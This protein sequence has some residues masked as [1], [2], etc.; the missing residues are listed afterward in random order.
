VLSFIPLGRG[1]LHPFRAAWDAVRP[2]LLRV[3][4]AFSTE[5]GAQE[6][7]SNI[8]GA[9]PFDAVTKEWLIG[10]QE[11]I[12]QPEALRRLGSIRA[13]EVRVPF[14]SEALDSPTL[15]APTFFHPKVYCFENTSTGEIQ[16]LSGSAN[17]TYR[18]L[19]TSI[20]QFLTWRGRNTDR[21]ADAF[22]DWWKELWDA[23]NSATA[24]FIDEY[25]AKRPAMP[26]PSHAL[27]TG[28]A[29]A[30]L[31]K[32]SSFWIELTRKPEGGS[33]NQVEL[34]FNGHFFFYPDAARPRQ[35]VHRP[36]TFEDPVG[37]L[38]ADPGRRIM[39]NGP[40]LKPGGNHMWRVYMPTSAQGLSGY[41]DGDAI[42]RF[43][44]TDYDDHHLIEIAPSRSPQAIKWMNSAT[45]VAQHGGTL[46]R[47]MGWS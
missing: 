40:P 31:R 1:R 23:A 14:G 20:D 38:Y 29:D 5:S 10:I 13:S 35:D 46:P 4:A 21:E 19:R 44:R 28:P 26:T 12:T 15:R 27:T 2:D 16:L 41:Q 22:N 45:G 24:G 47:R 34:L 17:L 39:Y 9:A 11:G 30:V 33:F 42:V 32:A 8:I 18:G 7:R 6:L 43:E 37:N 3:A 36:L 25:E